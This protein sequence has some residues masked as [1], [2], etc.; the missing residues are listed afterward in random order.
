VV[1]L[2]SLVAAATRSLIVSAI[3][4]VVIAK[5]LTPRV[6][7]FITFIGYL[8]FAAPIQRGL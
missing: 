3:A 7:D 6:S 5:R 8:L 1:R 4:E 2:P